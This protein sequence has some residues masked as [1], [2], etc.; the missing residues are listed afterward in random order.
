[1]KKTGRLGAAYFCRHNDGTRNDPRN[2]LGTIASQLCDCNSE[3]SSRMGGEDGVKMFLA[4]RSLGV[5]E[6]CTKL[7]EEPLSKCSTLQRKLV[8]IDALDE[9]EYKSREDFIC[10]IKERFPRFPKRL[11]FFITSRPEDM[12]QSR[13]E[14]YNPCVRICAGNSEQRSLYW[15]HEQDIQRFLESRVDFSRLSYSAEDVTKLC[16]GLFLHAFYI[17]KELNGLLLLGKIGKL[18]VLLPGDMDDFFQKNLQRVHDKVGTDLYSKL[19]GCIITAPSPL[20]VSFISFVLCREMSDLDEQEV[21]DAVSQFVVMQKTVTFLHNLIPAWLTN[22]RKAKKL[23]IDKKCA[24]EY[25]RNIFKEILSAVVNNVKA[26]PVVSELRAFVVHFGGRFLCQHGEKDSLKLVFSCFTSYHFL[27]ERIRSG[28]MGIYHLLKD[29]QL[30]ASSLGVEEEHEKFILQETSLAIEGDVHV[31]V[32]SPHLLR[33]TIRNASDVVQESVLIAQLSAACLRV[34]WQVCDYSVQEIISECSCFAT[35]SDKKTVAVARG[36]TLL[37]VDVSQ[38]QI[39][40]GP[41]EISQDTVARIVYL[42]FYS[43]DKFVFF[44]RLDKWFS[45]ERGC[46]EDFPQFSATGDVHYQWGFIIPNSQYIVVERNLL[47]FPLLYKHRCIR[48]LLALWALREIGECQE[49]M[50]TCSFYDAFFKAHKD[51]TFVRMGRQTRC[52][53][54]FL[55]VNP[56]LYEGH[57]TFSPDDPICY[58]CCRLK[59][60]TTANQNSCLA[61]VRHLIIELYPILYRYQVWNLQTGRCLLE[62]V[63][64]KEVELNSFTYFCHL[65]TAFDDWKIAMK[66][67]VV[68]R[69]V[70]VC[71]IS[72]TTALSGLRLELDPMLYLGKLKMRVGQLSR[73][74]GFSFQDVET[75]L[76]IVQ[77]MRQ[78]RFEVLKKKEERRYWE[79][80]RELDELIKMSQNLTREGEIM[81][82]VIPSRHPNYPSL[83]DYF[84]KS[85]C[86]TR[87]PKRFQIHFGR[88]GAFSLS[89][90]QKWIVTGCPNIFT[91]KEGIEVKEFRGSKVYKISECEKFTFTNDEL[92][93]IYTP[94]GSSLHAFSLQKD[95]GY[96]SVSG[97]DLVSLTTKGQFGYLFRSRFGDKAVFL[98]NIS[99]P[100]KFFPRVHVKKPG[101]ERFIAVRFISSD[102]VLAVASD[103]T[104]TLWKLTEDKIY[105]TFE[106]VP[107]RYLKT[108]GAAERPLVT[109]KCVFS[110]DGELIAFQQETRIDLH[111]ASES[112]GFHCTVFEAESGVTDACLKFSADGSLLLICM[113]ENLKRP[114]FYLWDVRKQVMCDSF[115]SPGLPTVDCFCLSSDAGKLVLCGG[116]YEIEIW[117]FNKHPCRLL[118]TL[119]VERFYKSVR[120]SQCTVSLDNELLVCCIGNLIYLYSLSVANVH[121]SRRILQGHLGKIEFCRF[122]K[123]NRYL[124]SYAVDGMVFLWDLTES[125]AIAFTRIKQGEE[126]IA[127]MALSPEEDRLVCFFTSDRVCIIKLC[128]LE[129]ALSSMTKAKV[130]TTKTTLQPT[131][132]MPSTASIPTSSFEDYK[133]ET[134]VNSDLE[135][136]FYDIPEDYFCESDESDC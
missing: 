121:S 19:L 43:D 55:G 103:S 26:R 71:K 39:V 4:N 84:S 27:E 115:K 90:G 16:N 86:P 9:T 99:S 24:S 98:T 2:L 106:S 38:L 77:W 88:D 100:F 14:K 95:I 12:L 35:A 3:Y 61:S 109:K 70:S 18:S 132:G 94:K 101:L 52:L 62:D 76:Q 125:K 11:V 7:L 30:A 114:L 65:T 40:G 8:V 53:L 60:I 36:R 50:R 111:C 122:L 129:S 135:D 22:K 117:E 78:M 93:L 119:E 81:S 64:Q 133:S 45:V 41:F 74:L 83:L 124:I 67:S 96:T 112:S 92:F 128:K 116:Y 63:F 5:Q 21:I 57:K 59:E 118:K 17:A 85:D 31:L 42:E 34:E 89:P 113:L 79:T 69:S 123:V 49:E 136:D 25:L 130:G 48:E 28:R 127:S 72:V 15:E 68:D 104:F 23:Y 47:P 58:Y 29:L 13:L 32:E 134:S 110:L 131:K 56:K 102:T 126:K 10:L 82:K 51:T 54:E 107:E 91:M 80:A 120:F 66:Y 20:P 1:M 87:L 108:A 44:G 6:L 37:F 46:V 73:E 97:R 75:E 33:S 105:A